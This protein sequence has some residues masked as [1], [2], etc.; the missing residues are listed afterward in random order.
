MDSGGGERGGPRIL[1]VGE[2]TTVIK[3][4]LEDVGRVSVEGEVSGL[5]HATSGHVYYD[6]GDQ[7]R[8][9]KSVVRCIIWKSQVARA[10]RTP[11]AN[12]DR[13]VVHGRLD[14]YAPRGTYS[15]ITERVEARGIGELLA[16]LEELKH[17]LSGL[18]WFGRARPLPALPRRIGVATS[19]SGAALHDFL[20]TRTRR[21]PGFPVRFTHCA[22]QGAG[23]A[24]EV[25]RAIERLDRSGVDVIVVCRGGGSLED[26]WCFNER[27]VAE[28][29]HAASVPVVSGVGHETDLTLCD[30]VA[31]HR[32]HTPTDAAQRVVPLRRDL[33]E[34][35]ERGQGD[36]VDAMAALL[37]RA[38]ERLSRAARSRVL[39]APAWIL[40][41][42]AGA[43]SA[44]GRRLTLRAGERGERAA[45]RLATCSA[46]LGA[47]SPRARLAR[48]GGRMEALALRLGVPARERCAGL[49]SRLEVAGRALEATSPL[50]VLGR[51][52]SITRRASDG[53]PLVTAGGLGEGERLET[54]LAEGRVLSR[55]ESVEEPAEDG[56]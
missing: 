1:T 22:V 39:R 6:L 18:G 15:L 36:L 24:E 2:L 4:R 20:E 43:L 9:V 12:G 44:A 10:T 37:E 23:A 27:P 50:A 21:W 52:Y 13:V 30:L 3:G 51:G 41:E 54:L 49:A 28:A 53:V 14:V 42:R 25:A 33:T 55:V 35:M 7:L 46:R 32:A 26:L 34:R 40:G 47:Q 16:R 31:D 45:A 48:L 56:A 17:E 38:D 19:R 8:G 29:I 11:L 5:T